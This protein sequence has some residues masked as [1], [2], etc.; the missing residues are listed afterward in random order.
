MHD[1]SSKEPAYA[2][3]KKGSAQARI[4]HALDGIAHQLV[5]LNAQIAVLVAQAQP[6]PAKRDG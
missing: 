2:P 5:C 4:I 3:L 6:G 1:P